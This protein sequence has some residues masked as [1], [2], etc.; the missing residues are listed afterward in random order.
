MARCPPSQPA[1]ALWSTAAAYRRWQ[2]AL[3]GH[4]ADQCFHSEILWHCAGLSRQFGSTTHRCREWIGTA[5]TA[6]IRLA[7]MA[8][9]AGVQNAPVL[10][11]PQVFD[12]DFCRQLVALY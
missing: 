11:V 2:H 4:G 1:V 3:V 12:R 7:A 6:A 5:E 10:I 9:S 8:C